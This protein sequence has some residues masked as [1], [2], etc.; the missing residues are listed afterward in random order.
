MSWIDKLLPPR[1]SKRSGDGA[2]KSMPEG[3]WLKCP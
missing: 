2:R 3:L 1:L